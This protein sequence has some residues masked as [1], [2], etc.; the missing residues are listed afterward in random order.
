MSFT[1]VFLLFLSFVASVSA[2][3][4]PHVHRGLHHRALAGRVPVPAPAPV[5]LPSVP[6][7]RRSNGKRCRPRSSSAPSFMV[8][9]QSG[10]GT[11]YSTGLGACGITNKD[12]DYIAAVSHLLFDDYPGYGGANS[13]NNPI[14][15]RKV[16]AS[17][18]GKT[19]TVAITDRCEG[20]ALDDLDFSPSAFQQLADPSLGRIDIT[21]TWN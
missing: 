18:K 3:A 13:N 12:S 14:C 2:L 9:T 5:D 11:F 16:T 6:V 10:Q 15:G 20:C 1:K 17:Y 8:G 7:R 4:T 19:V 21:W